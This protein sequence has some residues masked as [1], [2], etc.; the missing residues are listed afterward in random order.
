MTTNLYKTKCTVQ[1][2]PSWC[3]RKRLTERCNIPQTNALRSVAGGQTHAYEGPQHA[4]QRIMPRVS[5]AA[6]LKHAFV[7]VTGLSGAT[8]KENTIRFLVLSFAQAGSLTGRLVRYASA[9]SVYD[10][11]VYRRSHDPTHRIHERAPNP[12]QRRTHWRGGTWHAASHRT[13]G[14]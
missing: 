12:L 7:V 10:K 3:K 8:H 2:E 14:L 6:R 4:D 9:L 13:S 1:T 11:E 5:D